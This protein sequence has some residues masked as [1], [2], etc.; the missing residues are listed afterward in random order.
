MRAWALLTAGVLVAAG[1]LGIALSG[2]SDDPT[3]SDNR[4]ADSPVVGCATHVEPNIKRIDA[5]G[6]TIRGPFAVIGTV[7]EVSR[8]AASTFIARRGALAGAKLPVA[9]RAGHRATLRV[10]PGQRAHA[11]LLFREQ[12]SRATRI[13]DGDQ[14]ATFVPCAPDAPAFSG[15]RVGPITGWPGSVIVTGPRCVRLELRVDSSRLPD[16]R[17]PMGRSCARAAAVPVKTVTPP[18]RLFHL[19]GGQ[20]ATVPATSRRAL[21]TGAFAPS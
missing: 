14:A 8:R 15:G 12:T 17:L 11:A 16:I 6:N 20:L 13:E 21:P 9:L 18:W 5:H 2:G 7:R 1:V 10:S 3:A 19:T 4:A